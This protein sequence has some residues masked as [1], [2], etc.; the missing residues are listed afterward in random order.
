MTRGTLTLQQTG[1]PLP[2]TFAIL[3]NDFWRKASKQLTDL[4]PIHADIELERLE[5]IEVTE[6]DTAATA[7][8]TE[9][10][11]LEVVG[12][13]DQEGSSAES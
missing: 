9:K 10:V 13:Q 2:E 6:E 8:S 4:E 12:C 7:E 3:N 11:K 5:A 1:N